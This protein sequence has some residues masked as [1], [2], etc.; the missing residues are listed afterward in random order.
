VLLSLALWGCKPTTVT[1]DYGPTECAYCRMNVMD[2]RFAAAVVTAKGKTYVYDDVFCL[3]KHTHEQDWA[4]GDLDQVLVCDHARPGTLIDARSAVYA[5]SDSIQSPMAG[6]VAA[7][8]HR[9]SIE[10][11]IHPW[12][13]QVVTWPAVEAR[14]K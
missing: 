7:F 4:E 10:R 1:I 2:R 13:P 12:Q 9:D 6:G 3:V 11:Y 5:V 8:G 14:F